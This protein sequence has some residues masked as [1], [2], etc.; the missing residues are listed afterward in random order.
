MA[1]TVYLSGPITGVEAYW[2]AFE[3]AEEAAIE[4]GEIPLNPATLP[5]GMEPWQYMR[6]CMSM[7]DC[8]DAIIMLPGWEASEGAKV[9]RAYALY[10]GIPV[11]YP[12]E[13]S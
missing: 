6:I 4:R 8:A 12:H 9:E 2:L 3:R 5:E 7:L 10:A 13:Q 11:Y 1:R